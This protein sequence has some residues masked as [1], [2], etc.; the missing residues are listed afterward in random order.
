MQ[1][2]LLTLLA[3]ACLH[4]WAVA[5]C[6]PQIINAQTPVQGC[7]LSANNAQFWN[8][9]YWW[10]P[11]LL[12]HD[13]AENTL[14]LELILRDTCPDSLQVRCLLFLDLN[15]D[16]IQETVV[17]SDQFPDPNVVNYNNAFN[18][19]YSGGN[20]RSF[21]QRPVPVN[22]KYRFALRATTIG[23][24]SHYSLQWNQTDAPDQ[25]ILPELPYGDHKIRWE[26]SFG[27]GQ[28]LIEEKNFQIK[29]CK[30]PVVVCLNGLSVNIMPTQLITL[31]ATDFLQYMED[32]A[33]PVGQLILGVRK[34]GEG[35]GFPL[36]STGQPITS[37]TFGCDELGEQKVELWC[38]DVAGNAHY[39]E[40]FVLV[41]DNFNACDPEPFIPIVCAA[42]VCGDIPESTTY[43]FD[44]PPSPFLPPFTYF[45]VADDNGC[46]GLTPNLPISQDVD[47][48]IS[49]FKDDNPLEGVGPFDMVILQKHI[50]GIDLLDNPY[51]WIA[52]DA[53][54]DNV[55][56]SL[57]IQECTRLLLGIY[58]ELPNNSSWRFVDKTYVFPSPDPLSAPVPESIVVNSNNLPAT[59]LE[60]V[61]VKICDL[62]CGNLVGFYDQIRENQHLIG[63]AQPNPT[64]EGALVPIQLIR[65][66]KVLLE[67][68]DASGRLIFQQET[69]W[70]QGP[71][72]L[73]IPAE[74]MPQAGL[75]LWRVRAGNIYKSGKLV[76]Q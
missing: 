11:L 56:D 59:P 45:D 66:E 64:Q 63:E 73:E 58:S 1:K 26:I 68:L 20:P 47:I 16:G 10:D 51:Q 4:Q 43:V 72:A 53:N 19:N 74:A 61:A 60:F 17:D 48:T 57:D 12:T 41:Q 42:T 15:Y 27:G 70:P 31:W 37:V 49:P 36:G 34:S 23:D 24:S 55:L 7:D 65:P 13:L 9:I 8:E 21:D 29:D 33:T 40:T 52:A 14:N 39:C 6:S 28:T 30:K 5:Q 38:M 54:K 22:Q 2:L 71:A 75:Y 35:A 44:F 25:Y 62:S 67:V 46:G 3:C 32:N 76:R 69:A 50:D 18:P